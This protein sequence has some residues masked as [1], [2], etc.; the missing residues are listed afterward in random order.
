METNA[1]VR[2]L[3]A[4]AHPTRLALFRALVERAPQGA[5]AGELADLLSVVPNTLSFHLKELSA[6]GLV[7]GTAE[8]RFVRYR[9]E[10]ALLQSLLDFL[11]ANCCQHQPERCAAT[12]ASAC[13][14]APTTCTTSDRRGKESPRH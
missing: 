3:S 8:G 10:V 1:A 14:A 6:A 12:A 2:H 7:T 11:I 5:V 13:A 9:A 4:L